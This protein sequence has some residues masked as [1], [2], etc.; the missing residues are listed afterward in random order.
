VV[1]ATEG[2]MTLRAITDPEG[3]Y[4]FEDLAGGTW[5]ITVEM[6]GFERIRR[7]VT[8]PEDSAFAE[9]S[10]RMLSL[11]AIEGGT[12]PGFPDTIVVT[13]PVLRTSASPPDLASPA[14]RQTTVPLKNPSRYPSRGRPTRPTGFPTSRRSATIGVNSAD[15]R[16]CR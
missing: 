8:L 3:R 9:W 1:E 6:P 4:M 5:T 15:R 12:A 14:R 11:D 16:R 7:D 13:A 10:L 2:D